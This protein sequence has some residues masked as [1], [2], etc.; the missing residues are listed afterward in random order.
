MRELNTPIWNKQNKQIHLTFIFSGI[1][2]II[3]L[4]KAVF[5]QQ[6][7]EPESF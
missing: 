1:L 2:F 4:N 3:I 7:Y 5:Y 6:Y